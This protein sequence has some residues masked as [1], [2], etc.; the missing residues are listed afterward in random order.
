MSWITL[1]FLIAF[2]FAIVNVVDKVFLSKFDVAPFIYLIFNGFS[3]IIAIIF[4]LGYASGLIAHSP[5]VVFLSGTS[6]ILFLAFT[7]LYFRALQIEDATVVVLFV[8]LIP[9]PMLLIGWAFLNEFLSTRDYLGVLLLIVGAIFF[10]STSKIPRKVRPRLL[11]IMA[12]AIFLNAISFA[13]AK[14][15]SSYTNPT[16]VF[17]W[18]R[19]SSLLVSL[20]VV[21]H[22]GT[23]K[24][25]HLTLRQLGIG[26]LSLVCFNELLVIIAIFLSI[27]AYSIGPLALV[28][29]I[30]NFQPVFVLVIISVLNKIVSNYVPTDL[31][32][33]NIR[34]RIFAAVGL[35]IGAYLIYS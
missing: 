34:I 10:G 7:Y 27:M 17:F 15:A 21:F 29:S 32:A 13:T 31:D 20:L 14:Y 9:I 3:G 22:I 25:I 12:S 19:I 33:E 11:T 30:Q 5:F 24:K 6:G 8:R 23:R 28:S 18:S 4:I 35:I 2:L 26:K 16:N 1:G